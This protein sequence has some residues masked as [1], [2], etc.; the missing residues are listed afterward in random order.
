[1]FDGTSM[2]DIATAAGVSRGMPGYAFGSKA[3]L[4]EAVL[5]RAFARPRALMSEMA[6]RLEDEDAPTSLGAAIE[7]Y[8][9]FLAAHPTY[10][11]LLQRA[12]LD[13]TSAM[14]EGTANLEALGEAVA[15]VGEMVGSEGLRPVDPRQLVVSLLALCFFPFAH[16]STL[17][18]PLG[19]DAGDPA[20]VDERKAHLL[21]LV[22][23]GLLERTP[24]PRS[25]RGRGTRRDH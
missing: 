1:G 12:A 3:S 25:A 22:L 18:G 19:L 17:L 20:F 10:V 13:G 8:V 7:S 4:Y 9:D 15:H 6:A 21:D 24:C 11:R 2:Q 5:D 16:Q 23:N 14:G